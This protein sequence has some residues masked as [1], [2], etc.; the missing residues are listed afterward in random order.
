MIQHSRWSKDIFGLFDGFAIKEGTVL[1][2]QVKSNNKPN[3]KPFKEWVDKYKVPIAIFN[4]VDYKGLKGYMIQPKRLYT[5]E[6][7]ILIGWLNEKGKK[8]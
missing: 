1:F 6:N 2:F 4:W 8:D 5:S 3:P 7:N